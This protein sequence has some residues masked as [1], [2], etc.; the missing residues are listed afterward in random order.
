M[1]VGRD[2]GAD[3]DQMRLHGLGG[4]SGRLC[5]WGAGPVPV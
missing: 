1:S 5:I 4:V 2:H 3:L